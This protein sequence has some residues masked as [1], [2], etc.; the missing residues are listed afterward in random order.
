M[1]AKAAV[2][3]GGLVAADKSY[4]DSVDP[5]ITSVVNNFLSQVSPGIISLAGTSAHTNLNDYLG[6][7]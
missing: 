4:L 7:Y 2:T 6:G 1:T 5:A 3:A